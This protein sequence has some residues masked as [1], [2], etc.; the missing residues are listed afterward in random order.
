[1]SKSFTPEGLEIVLQK[2]LERNNESIQLM[3]TATLKQMS[4]ATKGVMESVLKVSLATT[5]SAKTIADSLERIFDKCLSRLDRLEE[6]MNEI[7][8]KM[9]SA[10]VKTEQNNGHDSFSE[11]FWKLEEEREDRKR[12]ERNVV[13]SGLQRD[14][15]IDDKELVAEFFVKNLAVKPK[16]LGTRRLHPR[17][18][19]SKIC[20]TVSSAPEV[21]ELLMSSV[22]LRSSSDPLARKCFVNRDLTKQQAEL[23]YKRRCERREKKEAAGPKQPLPTHQPFRG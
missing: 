13:I 21:E 14:P 7:S 10:A 1:M 9:E 23:E 15:Q 4:E 12:R 11:S 5:E 22:L 8:L 6:K 19:E 3:L 17:N 16:I 2:V 20:V 18:S